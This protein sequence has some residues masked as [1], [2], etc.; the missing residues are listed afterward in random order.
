MK[1]K[2]CV[3]ALFLLAVIS[4]SSCT[5]SSVAPSITTFVA[6][7]DGT[8]E[9]PANTSAATGFATFTYTVATKIM[10][11]TITLSGITTTTTAAHIHLGAVG[12]S[13]NPVFTLEDSGPFTSPINFTSPPLTAAQYADLLAGNYYVNINSTAYPNGEIR[14]QLRKTLLTDNNF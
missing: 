12:V 5:K 9:V 11:G 8:I 4:F 3:Y 2:Y 7:L 13:G 6:S 1:T 14:G 10:T